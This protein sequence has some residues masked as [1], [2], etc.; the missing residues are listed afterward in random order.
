ML[1]MKIPV[2]CRKAIA[3]CRKRKGRASIKHY[4]CTL[5]PKLYS[6]V[7]RKRVEEHWAKCNEQ[8]KSNN[9]N[10]GQSGRETLQSVV[11]H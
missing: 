5:C 3:F 2:E 11:I 9:Q 6:H 4:H 10:L 7:S 1:K 8:H